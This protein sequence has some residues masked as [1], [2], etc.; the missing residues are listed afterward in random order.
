MVL[1]WSRTKSL[2][3][4]IAFKRKK[5]DIY[6]HN[7]RLCVNT[8]AKTVCQGQTF[9]DHQGVLDWITNW[10]CYD[11]CTYDCMWRTVALFHKHNRKTPQ[12][13]GKWP[14]IR[15]FGMQE[16]AA[17][18]F[19]VFN[20]F[21][22]IQLLRKFLKRINPESPMRNVWTLYGLVSIN[23][24]I[25]ST[26]FHSRDVTI[27]EKLDYF[28]AFSIVV[29]SL[30][31][32]FLRILG[33]WRSP[34][35]IK[36]SNFV[37]II[38]CGLLFV[39]HIVLLNSADRFDYGYNMAVNVGVGLVNSFCWLFWCYKHWGK[40]KYVWNAVISVIMLDL[41]VLLELLD[42]VPLFWTLDAHA[43]WHLSTVPIH[44]FWYQFVTDD[45]EYLLKNEHADYHKTVWKKSVISI[46]RCCLPLF[47]I[48]NRCQVK[49]DRF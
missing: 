40:R 13:H 14:F 24:W 23:A 43:L 26:V 6:H 15:M 12:F 19:S 47:E 1:Y 29:Y 37:A 39:R 5:I 21:A 30:L 4:I 34:K 49:N 41:S 35:G 42:F 8:C 11:Q 48:G 10:Q 32:F 18:I 16:P 17:A 27:T 44:Y 9:L 25:C 46:K 45:C 3:K 38:A 36:W 28:S 22:H 20:L 7:F 33:S 2:E 31:A